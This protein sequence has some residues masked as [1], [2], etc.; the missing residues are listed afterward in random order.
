MRHVACCEHPACR[1][2]SAPDAIEVLPEAPGVYLFYGSNALP[3]YIGK[4]NNLRERVGAHFSSDYR[5]ATDLRL[6]AEIQ[7][8][9]FEET[10]G[11]IGALLREAALVKAM[12]PAHNHALRRKAE[13]GVLE[14]PGTPG[15]RTICAPRPSSR[16]RSPDASDRSPRDAR[17]LTYCARSQ[18][19][20]RSAGRR[21][22]SRSALGRAS[23]DS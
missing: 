11:E 6:S 21:S 12:L 8:I 7:R 9:E 23:P 16:V 20:T 3:P 5:S 13:S 17:R 4:S 15:R 19:S 2:S 14:L 22:V 18:A 10:A 1:R